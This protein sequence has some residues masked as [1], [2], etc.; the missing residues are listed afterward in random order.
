VTK[1]VF[2]AAPLGA[3]VLVAHPLVCDGQTPAAA[4]PVLLE[5]TEPVPPAALSALPRRDLVVLVEAKIAA[6]GGVASAAPVGCVAPAFLGEARAAVNAVRSWRFRPTGGGEETILVGV[7]WARL[8]YRE[9]SGGPVPEVTTGRRGRPILEAPAVHPGTFPPPPGTSNVRAG[10]TIDEGGI[11][12]DAVPLEPVN[13]L[14]GAALDAALRWRFKPDAAAPR[15]R[16]E[17]TVSVVATASFGLPR[18]E[19]P[20]SPPPCG[21]PPEAGVVAPRAIREA[22]PSY[23]Q[24]A[25]KAKQQG[26]VIVELL[27]DTDGSILAGRVTRSLPLLD[28]SALECARRWR[29]TPRIVNG[30][31]APAV[32]TIELNFALR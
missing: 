31:A 23:T 21:I 17:V 22:T 4:V 28:R 1:R 26:I 13:P 20:V 27:L 11:P 14:T 7:N 18:W 10:L 3:L 24:A 16:V 8:G 19:W 2:L 15:R 29:F 5:R 9:P 12:I 25:M 30:V 32:V 6:D